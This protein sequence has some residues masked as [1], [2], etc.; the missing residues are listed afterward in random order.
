M[1]ECL[2]DLGGNPDELH[3]PYFYRYWRDDEG[4]QRK[5]Y[6]KQSEL[7]TVRTAIERREA[8]LKDEREAR[9]RHMRRGPYSWK[10]QNGRPA[11]LERAMRRTTD[12]LRL[13][14]I[15]AR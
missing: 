4:K 1:W 3:G 5:A 2:D 12:L 6:V 13:R 8:R 11:M 14:G 15:T 9:K 7:E 10:A